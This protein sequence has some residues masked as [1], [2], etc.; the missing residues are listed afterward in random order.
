MKKTLMEKNIP[1][2]VIKTKNSYIIVCNFDKPIGKK[3]VMLL[4]QVISLIEEDPSQD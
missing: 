3:L 4:D 2:K 1:L